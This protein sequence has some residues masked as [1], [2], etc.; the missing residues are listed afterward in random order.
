MVFFVFEMVIVMEGIV[1]FV[2]DG[3]MNFGLGFC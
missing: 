2:W 3:N 1:L